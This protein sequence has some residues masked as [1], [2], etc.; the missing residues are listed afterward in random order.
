MKRIR[1]EMGG[2]VLALSSLLVLSGCGGDGKR[3]N[4][5]G[6]TFVY[7][8][9]SKWADEYKKATGVEVNYQS[10]GSGG[11][12]Q[13]MTAKTFDFGCTD[14]PMNEEQLSKCREAGGEAVH[15][16]LVLGAVVATYNLPGIEGPLKFTGPVLADIYLGKIRK[17][18]DP[19]LRD[20]NRNVPLPDQ[21]IVVIHR[22]DGSGTTYV[23]AEY[24][25]KVSPA[26]KEKVGFGTSVNWP[27]GIGQKGNEGVAGQVKRTQGS[28][29]YVELE[30]ALQNQMNVGEVQNREGV[31]VKPTLQSVKTAAEALLK[32]IPDD[33]RY[34]LT[35]GPG[36]DSYP[37]SGTT[38]AVLYNTLPASKGQLI[39]DFLRWVIHD[40]QKYCE[41]LH[42]TPLPVGLVER[43]EKKLAGIQIVP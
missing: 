33:L 22:S 16:P 39:L 35:N 38:W 6:S 31:F 36:K 8:M 18:N 12:I 15:I 2:V 29:G 19:S 3:L 5:G 13:Q 28:I 25:S 42:Y 43:A 21:D 23:W 27:T 24:L 17:W 11:G 40:G 32:E 30:Y 7:P 1:F 37:I 4:A 14:G 41:E 34:S 20:L 9:M 26:W 10:I